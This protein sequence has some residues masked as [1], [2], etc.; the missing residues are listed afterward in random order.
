MDGV[1]GY[2][3]LENFEEEVEGKLFVKSEFESGNWVWRKK[4]AL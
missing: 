2:Q 4:W 3:M 1:G